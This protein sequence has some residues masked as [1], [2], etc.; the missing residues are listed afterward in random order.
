MPNG[1]EVLAGFTTAPGV[2]AFTNLTA[3]T[4]DSF[5]IRA[6]QPNTDIRLLAMWANNNV[7]GNLR[8]ISPRL[9]D[10]VQGIRMI[11][12]V[13][14]PAPMFPR[15]PVQK[16]YSQDAL[17]PANTGSAVAAEIESGFLLIW[18]Q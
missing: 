11:A 8:V 12:A 10:N 6:A 15:V 9:H 16:L 2:A 7:Q 4:G 1:L 17:V 3:A 14:M 18:Y 5:T 13:A